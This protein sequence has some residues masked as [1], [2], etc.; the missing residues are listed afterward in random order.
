MKIP[1][2]SVTMLIAAVALVAINCMIVRAFLVRP[3]YLIDGMD[4]VAMA[5]VPMVNILAVCLSIVI[6]RRFQFGPFVIGFLSFGAMAMLATF[7]RL[8]WGL[9][10][11]A[12]ALADTGFE[13]W[14]DAASPVVEMILACVI[15]GALPLLFQLAVAVTGGQI[16]R[17]IW[18]RLRGI[19]H[20]ERVSHPLRGAAVVGLLLIVGT[21]YGVVEGTLRWSVDPRILARLATGTEA[22]LDTGAW[23]R[24]VSEEATPLNELPPEGTRLLV[25]SDKRPDE[26][27]SGSRYTG[28]DPTPQPFWHDTRLVS[29]R[30]LDGPVAGKTALVPYCCV[31]QNSD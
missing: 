11:L 1:R 17:V 15:V 12:K 24:W 29:V 27:V 26:G 7:F 4:L 30:W 19:W 22:S 10:L 18:N 14:I 6:R 5:M 13:E 31:R 23:V 20:S 2:V 25:V 3:N 21:S 16:S 9:L 28:S 8:D